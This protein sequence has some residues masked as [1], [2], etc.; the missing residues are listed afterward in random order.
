[1]RPLAMLSLLLLA[2]CHGPGEAGDP[3]EARGKHRTNYTGIGA[4]ET[5]RFTGTEPAGWSGSVTGGTL[6][7]AASDKGAG[8]TVP[9]RRFA[10]NNGLAFSGTLEGATFDLAVTEAACGEGAARPFTVTLQIG[11]EKRAGCGWTDKR[12]QATAGKEVG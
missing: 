8:V 5:L 2:A 10:G 6:T 1:M 12:K 9:V 7:Y 4:G 11:A 3:V